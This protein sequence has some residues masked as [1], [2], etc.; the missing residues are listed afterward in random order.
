[1]SHFSCIGYGAESEDA[2]EELVAQLVGEA[3]EQPFGVRSQHRLVS[4]P[5]GARLAMHFEETT[6]A[7]ITPWF[8]GE[9]RLRVR[10]SAPLDDESCLHCGGADCD[11]LDEKDELVTR[12]SVQWV[13][14]APWRGWLGAPRTF[15]LQLAAFAHKLTAF[16]DEKSFAAGRPAELKLAEN[17][18]LP[19]GMFDEGKSVTRR[20]SVLFAGKI[21]SAETRANARTGRPFRHLRIATLPGTIDVVADV[22]PDG[23][24]RPGALALVEAWLVGT[25]V[26]PASP[27]ESVAKVIPFQR[28]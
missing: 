12:A 3:Q 23:D 14:A 10:T 26:E 7:C 21:V 11:F 16:S 13:W 4:D 1:V 25:P 5:S 6:I 17:A 20:A 27:S 8:D 9:T 15:T 19:Y 24:P 2:F 22:E 18:F 28:L